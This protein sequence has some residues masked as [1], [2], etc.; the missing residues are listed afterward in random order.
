VY[1]PAWTSVTIRRSIDEPRAEDKAMVL[2]LDVMS[3]LVRDPIFTTVP[4]WLGESPRA[5]LPQLD[6]EVFFA[7]ERGEIDEPTYYATCFRDRRPVDGEA[8]RAAL[9]EGYEYLPGVET[10]LTDLREADVEMHA[11][12][13]YPPWF[14][15]IEQKLTLS[16]YLEWSFMSCERGVR[17]PDAEAFLGAARALE[18]DPASCIFVDDQPA[19]AAG[20][21]AVGLQAIRFENADQLRAALAQKGVV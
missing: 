2:L 11:L 15:M 7:F 20:A 18:R 17:K 13:N 21:S 3:T 1:R 8:F 16:R 5:L 6:R 14:H 4:A 12:S 9:R 19:N 10:L